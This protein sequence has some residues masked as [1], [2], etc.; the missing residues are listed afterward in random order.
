MITEIKG[1]D[2]T[3]EANMAI[4]SWFLNKEFTQGERYAISTADDPD[5]VR[6]TE[7][8]FLLKWKTEF[9]T[10]QHWVPKSVVI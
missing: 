5:V 8:A 9:G 2:R 10:I 4:K 6:E 3:L 1:S 7:K